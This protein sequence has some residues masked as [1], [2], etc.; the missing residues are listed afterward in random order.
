MPQTAGD[1]LDFHCISGEVLVGLGMGIRLG[2]VLV[3]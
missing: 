3:L 2:L 1:L